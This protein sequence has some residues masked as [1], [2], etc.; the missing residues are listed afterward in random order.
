VL[1]E[2]GSVTQG[3]GAQG[4]PDDVG[5]GGF[6]PPEL[7]PPLFFLWWNLCKPDVTRLSA[8]TDLR[9]KEGCEVTKLSVTT[10]EPPGEL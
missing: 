8:I 9:A 1:H 7:P 2:S 10:E 6:D 5:G 4:G 3:S